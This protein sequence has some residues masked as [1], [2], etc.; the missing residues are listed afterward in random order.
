MT[1]QTQ[2]CTIYMQSPRSYMTILS[3]DPL[4]CQAKYRPIPHCTYQKKTSC[5]FLWGVRVNRHV[6]NINMPPPLAIVRANKPN[7]LNTTEWLVLN[8]NLVF[9]PSQTMDCRIDVIRSIP[10]KVSILKRA[11]NQYFW[12]F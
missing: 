8:M 12:V 5:Q 6:H 1:H 11:S 3:L 2:M 7:K 9:Q 10:L 4:T